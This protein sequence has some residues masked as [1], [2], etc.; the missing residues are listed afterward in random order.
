ML[1]RDAVIG[2]ASITGAKIADW[3]ESDAVNSLGQKVWRLNMRT[4]E[5]QF[6]GSTGG[7]GRLTIN[8]K[9]V[10]VYDANGTLRVRMGV[11]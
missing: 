8:N 6:N 1:I 4:G 2:N 9:L 5:M 7:N 11:W 10:Q 3:L